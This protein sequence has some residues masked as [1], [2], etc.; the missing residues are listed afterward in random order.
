MGQILKL[1]LATQAMWITYWFQHV[2]KCPPPFLDLISFRDTQIKTTPRQ[3]HTATS[4][5]TLKRLPVASGGE[6]VEELEP[7]YTTLGNAKRC[8]QF[9]KQFGGF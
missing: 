9:G 3:Q 1:H 6:K 2:E 5:V 4:M 8:S 7:L